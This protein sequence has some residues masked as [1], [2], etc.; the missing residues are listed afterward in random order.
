M[1][2]KNEIVENDGLI[3]AAESLCV[4]ARTAPKGKILFLT[5]VE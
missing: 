4:A 1:L 2:I 5:E 3:R